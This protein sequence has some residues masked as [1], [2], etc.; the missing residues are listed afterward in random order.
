MVRHLLVSSIVGLVSVLSAMGCQEPPPDSYRGRTTTQPAES[1]SEDQVTTGQPQ[2]ETTPST[3]TPTQPANTG[4][5]VPRP[6]PPAPL[7]ETQAVALVRGSCIYAGCHAD[8]AALMVSPT[9]LMQLRDNLMPPPT[10]SRY[11]LRAA[12]R[13]SLVNYFQSRSGAGTP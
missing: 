7:N 3:G 11:T 8:A 10:Q 9:I 6:A 13:S 4:T 5:T 12:D 2:T 1:T